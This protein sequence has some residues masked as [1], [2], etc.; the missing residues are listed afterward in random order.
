MSILS[1]K[2]IS[3]R[4]SGDGFF[5]PTY[6]AFRNEV[7]E[8]IHF[9]RGTNNLGLDVGCGSGRYAYLLNCLGLKCIGVDSSMK[10]LKKARKFNLDLV[11]ASATALPFRDKSFRMIICI[12]LL[13]HF[14]DVYFHTVLK[15]IRRMLKR[16]GCFI[17]DAKNTFNVILA[18]QYQ[19]AD[20]PLYRLISRNVFKVKGYLNRLD[21][22]VSKITAIPWPIPFPNLTKFLAPK[23][24]MI[25]YLVGDS[26]DD[27][28]E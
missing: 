16:N 25:T 27:I 24:L 7:A 14:E 5:Q 4:Y 6:I 8:S 1:L 21:F 17:L 9:L 12:E 28:Q 13:H 2:S 15:E 18:I 19:I 11:C 20:S 10:A 3:R 23:I 26:G 22:S